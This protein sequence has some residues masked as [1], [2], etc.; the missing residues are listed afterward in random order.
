MP[1]LISDPA[2]RRRTIVLIASLMFMLIGTG[3]IYFIVIAL[4]PIAAEFNWPRAVPSIAYALQYAGAGIG[5]IFMGWCLDRR[6]MG[7]PAVVGASMIGLGGILTSYTSSPFEL[8]LIYGGML[9]FFG[10]STLFAPLT[11]NISRWFEHN[12]SFAVG[13]VG[14]GQ[15]LAGMIWPQV[16]HHLIATVGWRQTALYY[17]LFALTTMLPLALILR[18]TPPAPAA[19]R[20]DPR[21]EIVPPAPKRAHMSARAVQVTLSTAAIGCCVGMSLPL[22]HIVSHVSD[23]GYDPARGAETLSLMLACSALASFF[24]VGFLGGRFGGLRAIFVFSSGQALLLTALAFVESLPGLYIAAALFG[25]GY[26]GILPCYPVIVR[27]LLPAAEAGRRTGLVLLCAGAGMAL[28]SW[29]GGAV[30]DATGAYRT[31]FL[32]GVVFNLGNLAIIASLIVRTP[33][34]QRAYA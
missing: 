19:R 15:G 31:A 2:I 6:G 27:E 13:V 28:G 34:F 1:S 10:R 17:G 32:I 21:N 9:G 4:K 12:R 33:R 25:L 7:I 11:A 16:F 3:S 5:G 29:L 24:G 23:L 22:A 26:G 14:S 8:Y 20:A 18:Q 30:F